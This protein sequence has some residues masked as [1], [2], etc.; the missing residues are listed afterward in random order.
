[1]EVWIKE[2]REHLKSIWE[3]N[4]T[5]FIKDEVGEASQTA[6]VSDFAGSVGGGTTGQQGT[7]F[8]QRFG[9]T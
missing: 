7:L 2:K 8:P 5:R 9:V 3:V 6:Q 1:M 4:P